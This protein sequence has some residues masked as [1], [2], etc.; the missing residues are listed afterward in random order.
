MGHEAVIIKKQTG[1]RTSK[2]P[3]VFCSAKQVVVEVRVGGFSVFLVDLILFLFWGG[4]SW[5]WL[6]EDGHRGLGV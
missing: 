2:I 1:A 6:G 3:G 4:R 5:G